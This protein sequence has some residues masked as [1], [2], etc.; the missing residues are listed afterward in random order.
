MPANTAQSVYNGNTVTITDQVNR[1]IQRQTDG[2]GRLITV[3]EQ[4]VSTGALSQS[5]SYSYD[6][7]NNLTLVNQ[8]NQ[9]RSFKYDALKRML[10][11]RIP[12]QSATINDGIGAF[13]SCKY[14]YTD[15]NKIATRTAQLP[16]T[17]DS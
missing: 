5:T 2:L 14:T 3:N 6:Y 12:E 11:E 7:L 10:Y 15:F 8:G 9:T 4:D 1:K 17:R 13:W 16:E